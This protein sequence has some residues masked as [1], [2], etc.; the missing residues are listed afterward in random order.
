MDRVPGGVGAARD[1]F[2]CCYELKAERGLAFTAITR[3]LISY[4]RLQA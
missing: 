3:T 1:L 2:V 4:R